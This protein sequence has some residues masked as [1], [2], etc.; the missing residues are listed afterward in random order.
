MECT[1]HKTIDIFAKKWTIL[2]LFELYKEKNHKLRYNNLKKRLDGITSKMLSERLNELE[3]EKLLQ[4]KVNSSKVPI[5][6]EYILTPAGLDFFKVIARIKEWSLKW[7][8]ND[9]KCKNS[10]CKNCIR[11][12]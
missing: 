3:K 9:L 4:K 8:I 7:K 11:I 2:I 6:C 1:I 5:S 12:K 10:N